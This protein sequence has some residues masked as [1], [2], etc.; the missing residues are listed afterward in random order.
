MCGDVQSS[1]LELETMRKHHPCLE[2]CLLVALM[3]FHSSNKKFLE[4]DQK[5]YNQLQK[6][7]I[8]AFEHMD[9]EGVMLT[10]EFHMLISEN[11]QEVECCLHLLNTRYLS[12]HQQ[13]RQQL[14]QA[15]HKILS[16]SILK[17]DDIFC[18]LLKNVANEISNCNVAI[19]MVLAR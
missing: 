3:Y 9:N 6:E 8:A 10:A 5:K 19:L 13:E 2:H 1:I 11:Y 7:V 16:S 12:R 18:T 15:W 14:L 17:N 4:L